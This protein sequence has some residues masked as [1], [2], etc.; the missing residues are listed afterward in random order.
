MSRRPKWFNGKP[1]FETVPQGSFYVC[2]SCSR[3]IPAGADVRMQ[4]PAP[5]LYHGR[6]EGVLRIEHPDCPEHLA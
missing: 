6:P 5:R 1:W 2:D 3:T 4:V